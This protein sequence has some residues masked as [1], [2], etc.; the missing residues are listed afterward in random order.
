MTG[1][2]MQ[3][4]EDRAKDLALVCPPGRRLSM[5]LLCSIYLWSVGVM[6]Y[7]KNKTQL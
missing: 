7:W 1:G 3:R 6:E 5:T 2:R 4:T